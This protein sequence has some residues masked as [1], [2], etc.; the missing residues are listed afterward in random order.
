[1]FGWVTKVDVE[2]VPLTARLGN[3]WPLLVL[4]CVM[5]VLTLVQWLWWKYNVWNLST[6]PT[7]KSNYHLII[8][9]RVL[10]SISRN[11]IADANVCKCKKE[12]FK[13]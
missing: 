1:M 11:T 5:F 8:T 12:L 2:H 13:C 6:V 10:Q 3:V 4:I 7:A 9:S